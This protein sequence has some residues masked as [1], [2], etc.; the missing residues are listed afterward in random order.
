MAAAVAIIIAILAVAAVLYPILNRSG[1]QPEPLETHATSRLQ[2]LLDEREA[3]VNALRELE[4]DKALG[5]IAED[6]YRAVREEYELQAIA[7]MRALD[8]SANGLVE[9]IE[10]EVKALR[11]HSTEDAAPAAPESSCPQCG[12]P[13]ERRQ[14]SCPICGFQKEPRAS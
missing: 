2:V 8:E 14:G 6:K 10:E 1:R 12:S 3:L 4:N 9:E 13:G 7:V 5:N 11:L